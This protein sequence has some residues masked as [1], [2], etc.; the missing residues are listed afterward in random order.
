MVLI[1]TIAAALATPPDMGKGPA[2]EMRYVVPLIAFG[3]VLGGMALVLLWRIGWPLAIP[4]AGLLGRHELALPGRHDRSLRSRKPLVAADALL[5]RAGTVRSVPCRRRRTG[6][7]ARP[8]ARGHDRADLAV[9]HGLSADVL[10]AAVALLRSIDR[11]EADPAR[12]AAG[13]AGL[14]LRGEGAA[15]GGGGSGLATWAWRWNTS[16]RPSARASIAS[17]RPCTSLSSTPES[18]KFPCIGSGCRRPSGRSSPARSCWLPWGPTAEKSAA[19]ASDAFDREHGAYALWPSSRE[20]ARRQ[21]GCRGRILR[22]GP[23]A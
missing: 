6:R 9:V 21:L 23:A 12:L 18:R 19:L 17:A 22:S 2:A 15:G 4:V 10:R 13:V 1:Y 16:S 20:A 5:L 14:S 3:A 7:T 11:E 8:P